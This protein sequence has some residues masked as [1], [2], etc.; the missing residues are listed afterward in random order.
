MRVLGL[1]QG[2][3][4]AIQQPL[5]A[6]ALVVDGQ[7]HLLAGEPHA[8]I[9]DLVDHAIGAA[10]DLALPAQRR[11]RHHPRQR[12]GLG[13]WRRRGGR[14]KGGGPRLEARLAQGPR[15]LLVPGGARRR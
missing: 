2:A 1:L 15:E 9:H 10:A 4:L 11:A 5:D 14:C 13:G 6:G 12:K 8:T 3:E 7:G